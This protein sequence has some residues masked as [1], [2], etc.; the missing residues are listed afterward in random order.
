MEYLNKDE[1]RRLFRV[2]YER[3]RNH[4]LFLIVTLW[5]GLRV[6]EAIQIRATDICDGQLS[7][8]RL[9]K[10][11][12]TCQPIHRD[13]D[14]LFDESPLLTM[15]ASDPATSNSKLFPFSRQ[16]ADQ[17]IRRYAQLAGIHPSKAHMHALKHSMAMLLWDKTQSLG[18]IQGYLGH[19]SASSTMCYLVEVDNRKAEMAVLDITI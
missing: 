15:A 13:A 8:S 9:K 3:N 16:R 11:K 10:S 14:P 12:A 18:Q 2:A 5:H 17:F 19:K 1:L 4:H 7:V 6:S